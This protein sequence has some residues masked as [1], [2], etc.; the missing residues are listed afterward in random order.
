MVHLLDTDRADAMA[1]LFPHTT[2]A[3]DAMADLAG[4]VQLLVLSHPATQAA[5]TGKLAHRC[6]RPRQLS[7]VMVCRYDEPRHDASVR[8]S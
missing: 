7:D 6:D 8:T 4:L 5:D 2:Q 3:H 1:R